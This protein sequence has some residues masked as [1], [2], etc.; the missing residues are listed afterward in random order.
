[1]GNLAA[2]LLFPSCHLYQAIFH[3]MTISYVAGSVETTIHFIDGKQR[4]QRL[5]LSISLNF[6]PLGRFNWLLIN[7][8]LEFH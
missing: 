4:S 3:K 6:F 2:G 8:I 7:L 5:I 1:M